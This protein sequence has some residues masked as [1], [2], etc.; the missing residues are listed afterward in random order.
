MG[1]SD[2]LCYI[3]LYYVLLCFIIYIMV[4]VMKGEVWGGVGEERDVSYAQ[5]VHTT[6]QHN[7][8]C[9]QQQQQEMQHIHDTTHTI[10]P[11]QSTI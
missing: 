6:T 10:N 5:C 11:Q 9:A 8:Q 2:G 4:M 1:V 7:T 3:M